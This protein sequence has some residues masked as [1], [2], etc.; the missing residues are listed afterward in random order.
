VGQR[1]RHCQ[2]ALELEQRIG[3]MTVGDLADGTR[4]L[5]DRGV[6]GVEPALFVAHDRVDAA[7]AGGEGAA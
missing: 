5:A 4:T 3:D 7:P 1:F 2:V 6:D